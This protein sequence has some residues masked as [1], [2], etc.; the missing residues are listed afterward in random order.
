MLEL[1]KFRCPDDRL[2]APFLRKTD[3]GSIVDSD[4]RCVPSI[5]GNSNQPC[6]L[7]HSLTNNDTVTSNPAYEYINKNKGKGPLA[8]YGTSGVGKTRSCLD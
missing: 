7:L 8:L 6:L 1:P 4:G 2:L 5:P 3:D